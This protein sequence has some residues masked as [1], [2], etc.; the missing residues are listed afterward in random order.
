[1][2]GFKMY[3]QIQQLKE[4]GFTRCRVAKQ[5]NLN[6]EIQT[7]PLGI[8]A[9]QGV[10]HIALSCVGICATIRHPLQLVP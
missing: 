6:R 8:L 2:K 1:M 5:L 10:V 4:L 3:N 7:S 9:E